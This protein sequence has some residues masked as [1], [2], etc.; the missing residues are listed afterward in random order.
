MAICLRER[1]KLEADPKKDIFF[2]YISTLDLGV[3]ADIKN[4][5]I[6]F[7]RETTPY[8]IDHRQAQF[9]NG[10]VS[11]NGTI[12]FE[13]I[14]CPIPELFNIIYKETV[15]MPNII[16]KNAR[17]FEIG[18]NTITTDFEYKFIAEKME[19]IEKK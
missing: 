6:I 15:K 11:I 14:Y 17:M 19:T 7:S 2:G 1:Y 16:F 4:L 8:Y 18:L 5:N 9:I 10:K 13:K 3:I 12:V